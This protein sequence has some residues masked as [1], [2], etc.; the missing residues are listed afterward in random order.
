MEKRD[1]RDGLTEAEFARA[2]AEMRMTRRR[3][4]KS[5]GMGAAG[6]FMGSSLLAACGDNG[7][8][9]T[10][11]TGGG[12]TGGPSASPL[13]EINV[14]YAYI[15]PANDN[16]WTQTHDTGRKEMEQNLAGKVKSTY[17]E[18]VPISAEASTT[19]EQL[20]SSNQLVIANTEYAN[21]L[22]DVAARHPDVAFLECDGHTYTSNLSA[23]YVDHVGANYQLGVA[24]GLLSQSGK[25]GYVGAFPTATAFNDTNPLLLG[26]RTVNPNASVTAI[27]ISSFFDPQKATQATNALIDGGVDFVFAVMDEPSFLQVC[28]QRGVWGAA[29]NLDIR[30]F[31][32]DA[33]VNTYLLEWA[34]YYTQQAQAVLD[35]T[36]KPTTEVE[37]LPVDLG[38]WGDKIP[39]D[40]QDKV[41]E[42]KTQIDGGFNPYTGPLNDSSGAVKL[43]DGQELTPVQAYAIDWSVEGVTGVS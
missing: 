5:A 25:I 13:S 36:W 38:S 37:L 3:L 28:Q 18:N 23:Y 17:V 8:T 39:Q 1:P 20:A 24:A 40:V 4:L 10:P 15:G 11:T 16:G 31:G 9:T 30:Q 41:A 2:L 22:S 32:P 43:P 42:V 27:M 12:A 21:F 34:D 26:A 7:T 14:G 29:W 19:F 6:L 35:G 33:Y